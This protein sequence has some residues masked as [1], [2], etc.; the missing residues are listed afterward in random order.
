MFSWYPPLVV[1][2]L[3]D[4]PQRRRHRVDVFIHDLLHDCRLSRIVKPTVFV[5]GQPVD[6]HSSRVIA[7]R[8]TASG[9]AFPYPSAGPCE[10]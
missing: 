4:E 9:S 10:E 6:V 5:A 1:N 3:D 7:A 2:R 8:L